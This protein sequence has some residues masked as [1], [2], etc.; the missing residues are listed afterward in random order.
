M[1]AKNVMASTE[2]AS[3][4]WQSNPTA[5]YSNR[6]ELGWSQFGLKH[7][8]VGGLTYKHE[9]NDFTGTT[10][11][12]FLEVA[13]GNS[14]VGAGGNRYSFI[15]AGDVNGDGYSGNDLMYIPEN[16][17]DITLVDYVDGSGNTVT[18]AE[19]WTALNSFI[20]QDSYLSD[21]RGSIAERYALVNPWYWNMD[22]RILQDFNLMAGEQKHT[23]QL[24]VD[25]L[26]FGN[27]LSSSWGVRQVANSAVTTPLALAGFDG[28][29]EPQYTYSV[30][31][32]ETFQDDPSLFSRWQMQIGIRYMFN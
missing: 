29:G 28:S 15:V 24:S 22:L 31:V 19:Q 25:I 3:V 7:R 12:V 14:F 9:W 32:G 26:N 6:P 5:G 18:A 27:L 2:I 21:N 16:Q 4:L 20:E 10:V 8:V 13:Q 17:G 30:G 1:E 11:G 23:F